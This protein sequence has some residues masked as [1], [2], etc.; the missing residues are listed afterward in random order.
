MQYLQNAVGLINALTIKPIDLEVLDKLVNTKVIVY[1]QSNGT[2]S[3]FDLINK[4]YINKNVCLKQIALNDTYLTEGTV[5]E[6]KE[7]ANITYNE[8]LK[9]IK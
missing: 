8:I 4:Y 5:E 3:L 9:E 6:L 2:C 1:E 7:A